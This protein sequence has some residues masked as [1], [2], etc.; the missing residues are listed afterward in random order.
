[1]R[2]STTLAALSTLL[3]LSKA[4]YYNATLPT[5]TTSTCISH[6]D[7]HLIASG[8]GEILSNYNETFGNKLIAE[9][10]VDQS[11]SVATLIHTPNLLASNVFH[12]HS[13]LLSPF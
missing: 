3:S 4:E 11:D 13:P 8:F 10:Y 6:A 1:M 12:A 9:G 2:I 5:N 7:A